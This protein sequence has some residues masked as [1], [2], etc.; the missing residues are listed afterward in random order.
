MMTHGQ[1]IDLGGGSFCGVTGC[2][3]AEEATRQAVALAR[4]DGWR[5]RKWYEFWK[6]RV[7]GHLVTEY[8]SQEKA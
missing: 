6:V 7:P 8:E 5:P 2:E 1:D 4:G 3:T